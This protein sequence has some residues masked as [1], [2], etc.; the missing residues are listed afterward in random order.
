MNCLQ[1]FLM[2]VSLVP[3]T[4]CLRADDDQPHLNEALS[5]TVSP[6]QTK[7]YSGVL[8]GT[9][10]IT[11]WGKGTLVLSNAANDF[12]GGILI[13][14][15]YVKATAQ[16][17]LGT[18]TLDF[19]SGTVQGLIID[20]TDEATFSNPIVY[21]G[22]DSA[23]NSP[24]VQ[25]YGGPVTLTGAITSDFDFFINHGTKSAG[26]TDKTV[27]LLGD[28]TLAEGKMLG[29][30]AGAPFSLN[31][32]LDVPILHLS[33]EGHWQQGK[34]QFWKNTSSIGKIFTRAAQI[35]QK[36]AG[37]LGGAELCLVQ[38]WPLAE[39]FGLINLNGKNATLS[40]IGYDPAMDSGSWPRNNNDKGSLLVTWS[41]ASVVT[42]SG[43]DE[44]ATCW[45]K[46]D[47]A[48]SLVLDASG[49][50][51][52]VQTFEDRRH[53]MTGALEA[54]N[55]TMRL[56]TT[57]TFASVPTVT[58][59]AGGT[60]AL[61]NTSAGA[62]AGCTSL[63]VDGTMTI[64]AATPLPFTDGQ[65][66]LELGNDARLTLPKDMVVYVKSLSVGGIQK[67]GG[68]FTSANTPQI[69][70]DGVVIL[71]G[72]EAQA[73]S[74]TGG[75][76]NTAISQAGNWGGTLP[77]VFD[78]TLAAFFAES[79]DTAGIDCPAWFASLTLK[80]AEAGSGFSFTKASADAHLTV[81]GA[82][83]VQ[84]DDA[85]LATA[86]VYSFGVPLE[87]M[88]S[89]QWTLPANDTLVVTE[90]LSMK[91]G[92]TL[93]KDGAGTLVLSGTNR[94]AGAMTVSDGTLRVTGTLGPAADKA[95]V[96][97]VNSRNA[98]AKDT[99]PNTVLELANATIDKDLT[100]RPND[101]IRWLR[102]D[103]G[104]T[105]VLNGYVYVW[106]SASIWGETD[107]EIVFN[108]G[109]EI[110]GK[111]Y[112]KGPGTVLL[113][114]A[115]CK[116][117]EQ[118]HI[119]YYTGAT[120]AI[121]DADVT[122][123]FVSVSDQS[124][125]LEFRKNRAI[126]GDATRLEL[127]AGTID[128]GTTTQRF[129]T[130][131]GTGVPHFNLKGDASSVLEL[132]LS[133]DLTLNSNLAGGL[134]VSKLGSATLTLSGRDFASS[135]DLSVSEGAL[136]IAEDATWLNGANV[137]VSGTG[138]FRPMKSRRLSRDCQLTVTDDG[139]LSIPAGVTLSVKTATIDGVE[140][141]GGSYSYA[142]APEAL[143]RHF[144]PQA[145][146]TLSVRGGMVL[147]IR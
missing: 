128:F 85:D 40:A 55:G 15:G 1:S 137:T 109:L 4:F 43:K 11:K 139:V 144:D 33:P 51:D 37:A 52:F 136:A 141:D 113:Q 93:N 68:R 92:L 98:G 36:G 45:H 91:G 21:A 96:L 105:N 138:V 54:K 74:W 121:V 111:G 71:K 82:V 122:T 12:T 112:L 22:K 130:V 147:I 32:K 73:A 101:D 83:A 84:K 79:G 9:T 127:R 119:G 27:T 67:A 135:G 69:L 134:G 94:V 123:P 120:H 97:S 106:N 58:V 18:G 63:K 8:S 35:E 110:F 56:A 41:D 64:S 26:K 107:G 24:S 66:A 145:A 125:T 30:G 70:G 143:R 65:V 133:A 146:G 61:D 10:S 47:G 16:G 14:E 115:A 49:Y 6:G 86:N 81:D 20:V 57:V 59:G 114:G 31:C 88:S 95:D 78:G 62:L 46:L 48:I 76:A 34:V 89:Q 80:A 44:N 75:G 117:V 23:W 99:W 100:F 3:A 28:V 25:I 42:I 108:G 103:V 29:I 116:F 19:R 38:N 104:S 17:A 5:I 53:T 129:A 2:I 126:Q 132:V 142:T 118:L 39:S 50:P 77:N 60:L 102:Q 140:L 13:R 7:V 90:G 124:A 72:S 87:L 131:E